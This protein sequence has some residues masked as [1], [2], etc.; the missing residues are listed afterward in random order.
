MDCHDNGKVGKVLTIEKMRTWL[1]FSIN[2]KKM[3]YYWKYI[4]NRIEEMIEK[5]RTKSS[6]MKMTMWGASS[7]SP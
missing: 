6:A 3:E 4:E 2:Y 7:Y 5:R 1:N